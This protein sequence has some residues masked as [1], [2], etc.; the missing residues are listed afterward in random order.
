MNQ[1][2]IALIN[3]EKEKATLRM[4]R[5]SP[6]FKREKVGKG[7]G[8]GGGAWGT[9]HLSAPPISCKEANLLFC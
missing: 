3:S 5:A 7:R 6:G 1:S 2:E 9:E 4:P 8:G